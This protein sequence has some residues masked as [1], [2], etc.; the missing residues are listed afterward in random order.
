MR[1]W[2]DFF[3]FE[4]SNSTIFLTDLNDICLWTFESVADTANTLIQMEQVKFTC[5]LE[6]FQ[7][8]ATGAVTIQQGDMVTD[9]EFKL[10]L[11]STVE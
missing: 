7:E 8:D 3:T 6:S 2:I 1:S 11:T 4:F 9:A 5:K 10:D